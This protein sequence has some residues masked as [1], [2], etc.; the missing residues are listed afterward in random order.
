MLST[1]L[2]KAD[3]AKCQLCCK[4]DSYDI[5]QT[6]VIYHSL[7]SKILQ[8]Y[9]HSLKFVKRDSYFLMK[10]QREEG[11]D[12]YYCPLLDGDKGCIMDDDKPFDCMIWPF[13]IMELSGRKVL[14]LSPA[15]P[16]VNSRKFDDVCLAAAK[17]APEIFAMADAHP[18]LVR[19]Y[20][21]DHP[22]LVIEKSRYKNTLV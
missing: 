15:C 3:C 21:D 9:S 17:A 1:L 2:S 14:T 13:M 16:I 12:I 6:P 20:M 18:E 10:M 8:E 19:P 4:F 7:A 22:I 5:W 11:A